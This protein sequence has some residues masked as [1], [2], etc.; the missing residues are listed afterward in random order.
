MSGTSRV[1][2]W[3]SRATVEG[4]CVFLLIQGLNRNLG[5]G[6]LYIK[7]GICFVEDWSFDCDCFGSVREYYW[8]NH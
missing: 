6:D 7:S 8:S 3:H 2:F 4:I 1:G 5:K